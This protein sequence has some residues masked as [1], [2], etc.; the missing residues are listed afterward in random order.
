MTAHFY[1]SAF[2]FLILGCSSIWAGITCCILPETLGLPTA[3]TVDDM[4]QM[5]LARKKRQASR[6]QSYD[7][8]ETDAVVDAA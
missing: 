2:P 6:F 5:L 7:R 1:G 4:D 3:E 8:I